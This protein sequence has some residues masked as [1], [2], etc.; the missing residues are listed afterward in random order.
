MQRYSAL[1]THTQRWELESFPEGELEEMIALWG[2]KYGVLAE[3]AREILST[4]LAVSP[5][6]F[7]DHMVR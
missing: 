3:Q 1:H 6:L 5:E 4:M 7:L 2:R